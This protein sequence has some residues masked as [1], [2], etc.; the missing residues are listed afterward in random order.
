LKS[1]E[2]VK[3][4]LFLRGMERAIET[5]VE[6]KSEAPGHRGFFSVRL[7]KYRSQKFTGLFDSIPFVF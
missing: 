6:L 4:H 2:A 7:K 1:N 5:F 3:R